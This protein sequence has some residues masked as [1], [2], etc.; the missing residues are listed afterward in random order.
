M[1]AKA[2]DTFGPK[3]DEVVTHLDRGNPSQLQVAGRF[4]VVY[5]CVPVLP[6]SRCELPRAC[7]V[8]P[9]T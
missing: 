4:L 9:E 3:T 6:P 5:P 1:L 2:V 8:A 7:P